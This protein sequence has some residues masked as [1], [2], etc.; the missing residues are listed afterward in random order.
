MRRAETNINKYNI[1]HAWLRKNYGI[2]NKCDHRTCPKKSKKFDWCLINGKEYAK[3]IS[4]FIPLC[5]SCH[6]KY[7]MTDQKREKIRKSKIGT[8]RPDIS[9]LMKGNKYAKKLSDNI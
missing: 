5:R 2:A 3:D 1:I 9:K 8:K 4:L 7:D 6:M